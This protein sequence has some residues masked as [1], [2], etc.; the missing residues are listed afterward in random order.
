MD[1][2]ACCFPP[3][4]YTTQIFDHPFAGAVFAAPA[5]V[6][7]NAVSDGIVN[8]GFSKDVIDDNTKALGVIVPIRK[9]K[10]EH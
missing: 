10:N 8:S 9:C 7:L 4:T 1:I 6:N 3:Y 5:L 2:S